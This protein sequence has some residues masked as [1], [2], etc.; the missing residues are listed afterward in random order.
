VPVSKAYESTM[1]LSFDVRGGL[2][3]R[4]VHHWAA[5]IFVAAAPWNP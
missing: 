3:M 1:D 2:L 5:L 4:Q